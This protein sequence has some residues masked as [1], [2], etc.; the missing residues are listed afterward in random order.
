ME[1][2]GF[3]KGHKEDKV[4]LVSIVKLALD[5]RPS[6]SKTKLDQKI[7]TFTLLQKHSV[8]NKYTVVFSIDN[9]K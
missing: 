7:K 5:S 2:V 9:K 3:T 8:S 1:L 4:W 6:G